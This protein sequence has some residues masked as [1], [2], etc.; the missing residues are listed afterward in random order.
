[1]IQINKLD[2]GRVEIIENGG[3][4]KTYS[5][6]FNVRT[7]GDDVYLSSARPNFFAYSKHFNFADIEIDGLT[8]GSAIEAA[9]ALQEFVADANV[10]V[11]DICKKF[12]NDICKKYNLTP[13]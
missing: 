4:G 9:D 1:M 5:P 3:T 10:F 12:V 2:S 6:V 13:Q 7:K 11:N 8:Y